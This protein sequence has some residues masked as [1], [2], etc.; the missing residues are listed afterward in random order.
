MTHRQ[1]LQRQARGFTLIE[2]CLATAMGALLLAALAHVARLA[3]ESKAELSSATERKLEAEFVMQRL[4]TATRTAIVGSL[5]APAN[6]DTGQWLAPKRFC[7][8]SAKA[9]VETTA[10]D[11]GC[12]SGEV[13]AD[14]VTRLTITTPPSQS[15][16]DAP[17][18]LLTVVLPQDD[19]TD[20]LTVSQSIRLK[21][22][23][24]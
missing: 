19:G 13:I 17:I 22:L 4:R 14:Q 12:S 9:L 11:N 21:G 3:T 5:N 6:G 8:N 2:L 20:G 23:L 24:E 15:A 18:A 10:S 1:P 7:I 16:L